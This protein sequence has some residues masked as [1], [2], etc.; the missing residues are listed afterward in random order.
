MTSSSP[1]KEKPWSISKMAEPVVDVVEQPEAVLSKTE[2]VIEKRE[3]SSQPAEPA[4][5]K[6]A[7]NKGGR[8]AGSKDKAP[9][10]KKIVE[11]PIVKEPP[12]PEPAQ[13]TPTPEPEPKPQ[14]QPE[15]KPADPTPEP[16]SP[17][18]LLRESARHMLEL[19]R[20]ND[21]ARKTHLQS[22][23]TRRL[24]AF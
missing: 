9:R 8:P 20:L 17:R 6:P 21:S 2:A 19:K 11:V 22:A 5:E 4:V 10:R 15:A 1:V 23:Y 18:A 13:T 3:P 24:A 16:L 14:P 7:K 12:K